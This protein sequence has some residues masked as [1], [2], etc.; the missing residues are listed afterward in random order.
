MSTGELA[1]AIIIFIAAAVLLFLAVRHFLE[2]GYLMNNS[3][4]YVSKKARETMN[5]KP[6]YRQS[7][8]ILCILSAVFLVTGLSLVFRNDNIVFI[9]IPLIIIGII[10]AIVSSVMIGKNEKK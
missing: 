2:K 3:Y 6:Y 10:Y 8:I 4:I 9:N 1:A 5:K 7:G